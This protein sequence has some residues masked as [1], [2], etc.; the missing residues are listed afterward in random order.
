LRVRSASST[1]FAQQ[2]DRGVVDLDGAM[3][4]APHLKQAHCAYWN[5]PPWTDRRARALS[6][7][8]GAETRPA[9]RRSIF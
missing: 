4:D 2:P 1:A 7:S 8:I 5:A 3:L 9:M 6:P